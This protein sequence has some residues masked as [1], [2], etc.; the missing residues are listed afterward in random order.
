MILRPLGEN[1]KQI[2]KVAT[3]TPHKIE[4]SK[5]FCMWDVTQSVLPVQFSNEKQ[6]AIL[7]V[8][9]ELVLRGLIKGFWGHM[10]V[11]PKGGFKQDPSSEQKWFHTHNAVYEIIYAQKSL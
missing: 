4:L 9:E 6:A 2:R 8:G 1:R 3:G 11:L 5:M 10:G 7:K